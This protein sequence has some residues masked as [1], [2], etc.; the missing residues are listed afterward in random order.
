LDVAK[1]GTNAEE[2]KP[3]QGSYGEGELGGEPRADE[4]FPQ[5]LPISPLTP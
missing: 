5:V 3:P 1:E 2:T 4:G